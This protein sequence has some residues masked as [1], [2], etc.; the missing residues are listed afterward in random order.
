M[1]VKVKIWMLILLV[2]FAVNCNLPGFG[3]LNSN[4]IYGEDAR[5]EILE[6]GANADLIYLSA[7][8][9]LSGTGGGTVFFFQLISGEL[10][11]ATINIDDSKYYTVESVEDCK[12]QLYLFSLTLDNFLTA[13]LTCDLQEVGLIDL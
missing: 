7:S 13:A 2:G 1:N 6:A 8:G 12:T 4:G 9:A 3:D 11:N 10:L 5:E